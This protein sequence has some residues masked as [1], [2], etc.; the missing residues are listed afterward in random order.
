MTEQS[1]GAVWPIRFLLGG[2]LIVPLLVLTGG[3]YLAYDATIERAKTN[4]M[5][6]ASVA[7][8][9]AIKVLDTH[10]LIGARLNDL[11]KD[12]DDAT[13]R[14][15][16][17]ELHDHIA[18]TIKNLPQVQTAL[19]IDRAGRPLVS[20]NLFPVDRSLDFSDRDY[21][22]ALQ[23]P[24]WGIFVSVGDVGPFDEDTRFIVARRKEAEPGRFD[25]VIAVTVSP[26]Y[27][28]SFYSKLVDRRRD[29]SAALFRADGSA[30][31]RY[32]AIVPATRPEL[33]MQAITRN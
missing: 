30:L 22:G 10:Q 31:A 23:D 7:E 13:I 2:S 25:G 5:R 18:Q 20:A 24:R 16:E 21:F 27:F 4:L 33:L 1:A 3:G 8:E 9:H 17:A 32:P 29:H 28:L 26:K 11:V 14:S 19:I 12:L 6:A 15:R